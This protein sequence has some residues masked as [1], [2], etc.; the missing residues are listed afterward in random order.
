MALKALLFDCDG[1]LAETEK[2]GHREA[3]N[4]VFKQDGVEAYW[5]EE[6]Y[7]R[8]LKIGGGKERMQWYFSNNP[9]KYPPERFT[10]G[11]ISALHAMKTAEFMQLAPRLPARP[12]VKRLMLEA[13]ESGVQVFICST[14]N[15][16]SVRAI[17]RSL[18]GAKA[19]IVV[20]HIFAGDVVKAKKPAP[21]IYQ[22]AAQQFG[23]ASA[24]CVV[25]EDTNIGLQAAKGAGMSCVIT[26][27][28]YSKDEDFTKADIV[29]DCLGEENIPCNAVAGVPSDTRLLNISIL[30]QLVQNGRKEH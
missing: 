17:A 4:R 21:D 2:D 29:V 11:Y 12:G 13:H 3:F 10:K 28:L 20:Q 15:E 30:Q 24:E 1:V 8:L 19:D 25:I 7:G 5:N 18:L 6:E 27:S 22:L 16:K 23:L 26:R 9:A 14:S